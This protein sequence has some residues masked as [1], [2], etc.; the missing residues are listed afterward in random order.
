MF[1][2][3]IFHSTL[4]N[5]HLSIIYI[6]IHIYIYIYTDT[7]Y[8]FEPKSCG[9]FYDSKLSHNSPRED[10]NTKSTVPG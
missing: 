10:E 5:Q 8:E 1:R 6:Y 2:T 7:D 9:L 4:N 3:L